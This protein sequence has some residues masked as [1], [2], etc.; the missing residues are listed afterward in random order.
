MVIIKKFNNKMYLVHT[1]IERDLTGSDIE[2]ID[3]FKE[4][5]VEDVENRKI[6]LQ[7]KLDQCD[8]FISQINNL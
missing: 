6:A 7:G 8:D 1:K 4:I 5:T 3:K 2:V